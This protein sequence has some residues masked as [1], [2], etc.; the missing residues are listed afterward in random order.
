MAKRERYRL[1]N[2]RNWERIPVKTHI[3]SPDDD[4]VEV[5]DRYT[6][7]LRKPG[8]MIVVAESPTAISQG[9][10]IPENE[11][12]IGLMARLMWR[13]VRKVPYG[14]GLRS[15]ATFQCAIN[16]AG[17]F[18]VF[19]ASVVGALGKLIGRRGDFYRIAGMQAATIDAAH[20]SPVPPY[21][22][23]VI[24]GPKDPDEVA[25]RIRERT[26]CEA[27]IM[28]VN[29]IGGSWALGVSLGMDKEL[30][31]DIMRDNPAGQKNECTPVVL[32]R[33]SAS[34]HLEESAEA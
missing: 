18:R 27:A 25:Q 15:P 14:V 7:E 29:D 24:M 23:C 9:R 1:V 2:D 19:I 4:I 32:V 16:E 12:R 22:Q 33:E 10:A 11:I 13:G 34:K 17:A 26:G 3:I 5:A 6:A 31:Q 28:D 21:D 30:I 20:T 8:D